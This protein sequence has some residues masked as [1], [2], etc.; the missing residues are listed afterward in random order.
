MKKK[1][2]LGLRD[3]E[4]AERKAKVEEYLSQMAE[5]ADQYGE[6]EVPSTS[7]RARFNLSLNI[8]VFCAVLGS[9]LVLASSIYFNMIPA[10]YSY[11][12]TQ[13]GRIIEVTPLKK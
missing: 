9:S 2:S 7:R 12:T 10:P 4:P 6:P 3:L 1:D 8:I 13:D 5:A 11:V